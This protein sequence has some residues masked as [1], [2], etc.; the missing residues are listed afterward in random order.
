MNITKGVIKYFTYLLAL[1]KCHK[2]SDY[3]I[4]GLW[5]D[6]SKG[7][8]PAFCK[9]TPYNEHALQP[10]KADLHKYWP[11]CYKCSTPDCDSS[12]W[13]HEWKKHATCF[14]QNISA[15]DYFNT[16]LNLYH[17]LKGECDNSAKKDCYIILTDFY[18]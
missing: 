12:L 18:E 6:Y 17:K 4:H 3:T 8:Y 14:H 10:I 9:N 5:I 7:G 11:S 2:N 15:I 1:Q 13:K 16:T